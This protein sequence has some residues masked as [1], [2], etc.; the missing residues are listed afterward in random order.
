MG[1]Y[2]KI[3]FKGDIYYYNG[4]RFLD[5]HFIEIDNAEQKRNVAR[6]YF[7]QQDYKHMEMYELIDFIALVRKAEVPILCEKICQYGLEAFELHDEFIDSIFA[8]YSSA[9]RQNGKSQLA[10]D[11]YRKYYSSVSQNEAVC[12]SIGA[13]FC[14]VGDFVK[15]ERYIKKAWA[16][17][18]N[19]TGVIG[20]ELRLLYKRL[21]SCVTTKK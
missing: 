6:H 17:A 9:L 12:T 13:A 18:K 20:E 8:Y 11:E 4:E 10:I 1:K 21:D 3:E 2:N 7:E 5:S 15:A 14:D 19:T 16:I